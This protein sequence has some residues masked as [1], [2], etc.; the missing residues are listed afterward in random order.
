MRFARVVGLAL[1]VLGGASLAGTGVAE[2]ALT[3]VPVKTSARLDEHNPVAEAGWFGWAQAAHAHPER[4]NYY[5]RKG[6]GRILKVNSPGTHA[7]GGGIDGNTLVYYEHRGHFAGDIRRF[8]LRTHRRTNFPH[9]VSSRWDEYHPTVSGDWVLFTR[10]FSTTSTT[11]VLLYN[12]RTGALRSLGSGSSRHRYVYSGQIK[13]DFA[14]WGRVRPGGQDVYRYRISTRTN[15]VVP[16]TVFAQYDPAVA[17]DGTIYY[18]RSGSSC[19]D[20]VALVRYP[21]G[22]PATVLHTYP[23]G[24]DGGFGYVQERGNG[25]LDWF[26]GQLNCRNNRWDIYKLIDSHTVSVL[27]DGTGTGTV[28]SDLAGINC[29]TDCESTFHGGV[30][31]T[32]TATPDTGSVF[33]SWS[34][35]SCGTSTTCPVSVEDDVTV[36]ATFDSGP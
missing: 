23:P 31:V 35:P 27:K 25:S 15:T 19:G 3:P 20:G 34:D 16:R 29:G 11:K 28:A 14:A 7:A 1:A 21:L 22:G 13:G 32:L 6:S 10:Y 4:I 36:T 2:A 5:V 33:S 12:K 30:T 8:N 26:F 24:T 9:K 17:S 18:H